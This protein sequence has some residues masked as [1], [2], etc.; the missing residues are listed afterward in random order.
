MT[1]GWRWVLRL[2]L[3]P[4]GSPDHILGWL[5]ADRPPG[6][7]VCRLRSPFL[8]AYNTFVRHEDEFVWSTY[9]F[10]DRAIARLIWLPA[11]LL[12]R[13]IVRSSLARV[14]RRP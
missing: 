7:T 11:S 5:I 9:V 4:I 10:Y 3:G 12:H 6:Q 1:A 13:R 8:T 2:E 14:R